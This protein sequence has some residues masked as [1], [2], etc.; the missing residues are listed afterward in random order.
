MATL[1][2]GGQR[3]TVDDAFLSLSPAQQQA[4]VE[5]IS[6][7]LN[8]QQQ[9]SLPPAVVDM[10]R[11]KGIE[12]NSDGPL[13][14]HAQWQGP[15]TQE[16]NS[17]LDKAMTFA[18]GVTEGIPIAGPLAQRATDFAISQA[19]GAFTDQ[20]PEQISADIE[21]R[22]DARNTANPMQRLGGNLLSGLGTFG[23]LGATKLGANA[24]GMTGNLAARIGNSALSSAGIAGAD[25]LARGASPNQ[26]MGD[27]TVGGVLGAA[28]PAIGG[29][30]GV[31]GRGVA[32]AVK[33]MVRGAANP[34]QEAASVIGKAFAADRANAG[35]PMI[36]AVDEQVAA[37]NNQQLLNVERGGANV[38]ALMR[39]SSNASPDAR[40]LLASA[41]DDNYIGQQSRTQNMLKRITGLDVD[42][43]LV[44]RQQLRQAAQENANPAYRELFARPENQVVMNDR[45]MDLLT[46][47][48]MRKVVNETTA[49]GQNMIAGSGSGLKV[50]PNPFVFARDGSV[51][52]KEGISPT[53]EFWNYSKRLL[54]DKINAF[55]RGKAPQDLLS[56]RRNLV[57]ILDEAVPDYAAVRGARYKLFQA[58]DAI[59]AG[60]NFAKN[61]RLT[62]PEVKQALSN[63]SETERQSFQ[64]GFVSNM[65]RRLNTPSERVDLMR[66]FKTPAFREQLNLVLGENKAREIEQF[67][68]VEDIKNMVRGALGN[69]TT[70]QQLS[71]LGL[72]GNG[73]AGGIGVALLGGPKA[74]MISAG[75]KGAEMLGVAVEEK[76]LREVANML[77]SQD[78]A[79]IN[80]AV[81]NAT[82]SPTHAAAL[83]AIQKGIG[84]TARAGL[85]SAMPN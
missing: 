44:A 57:N 35:A 78:P 8:I 25:Q 63:M 73:G 64:I 54:D 18:Q 24:L 27:M 16:P 1:N 72:V 45:L 81:M 80:R 74:W 22:R 70:T 4:T 69:S 3:V 84:V 13:S 85:Q 48:A 5:E 76:V 77:I 61:G 15:Q 79:V 26:I 12:P 83:E 2:I 11:S 9:K 40:T 53:L 39:A 20:T 75:R 14:P 42:S 17:A 31:L 52:L 62:I 65:M 33:P 50:P 67:V 47:P 23:T 59:Q 58:E 6:Q 49:F 55:P 60:E 43:N 51:T 37:L 10:M 34:S 66:Q 21:A 68:R 41:V 32:R 29:G 30:L 71:D 56:V 82:L 36:N 46:S 28:I 19:Q 7:S 38:R